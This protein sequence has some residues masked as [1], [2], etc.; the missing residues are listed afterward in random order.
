MKKDL[1]NGVINSASNPPPL[2]INLNSGDDA[3]QFAENII[4]TVREPLIVLDQDLKVVTASRSFYDFFKVKSDETI[5]RLIYDLGNL[6]WN[7]PKLKELLETILPEKTTFD[8][9]EVEHDFPAIGKRVMLL[10]ARQ[11]E[12]A[13]GKEKIILL[14][15]EDITERRHKEKTLSEKNRMT[16]EYLDILLDHA[17]APII[18]WD[19]SFVIKRFNHEFEK[20]SGYT[21]AEVIDKK[22]DILFSEDKIDLTLELIKSNINTDKSEN[23]DIDILT[24]DKDIK[25]V[26]WNSSN[27]FDKEGNKIVA[28]IAQDITRH[29]RTEEALR[30]SEA[31]FRTMVAQSPDGIF[32]TDLSGAFLSVNKAMCDLLKY[33]EEELLSLNIWDIVPKEY[34]PVHKARLA[35]IIKGKSINKAVEY[36]VKGKDGIVHFV[37]VLSTPFYKKEKIIGAQ[38]IARDITERKRAEE[39]LRESEE[40]FRHSFDYSASASC[41]IST[42]GKFQKINKAFCEMTGYEKDELKNLTFTAITHPDDISIGLY[43]IKQMLDGKNVTVSFEKR[44]IRKDKRIIWCHIS[45]SLVRNAN[46][47]PQFFISQII[48]ITE[49]KQKEESLRLFRT[50]LDKSNDAIELIDLAT[51][52]FIDVNEKACTDL[53]YSRSELLSMS[54]FDIDPNQTPQNYQSTVSEFDQSKPIIIESVHR[55]KDGSTFPVEVNITLVKL[56]KMYTIVIVRNL[57]ERKIAEKELAASEE[58]YRLLFQNAAEGILLVDVETKEYKLVNK[59]VCQMFGYTEQEMIGLSIMDMHPPESLDFVISEFESQAQGDRPFSA[60]IPCLRKDGTLFYANI[61]NAVVYIDDRKHNI[62]F[63]TDVT[64]QKEAIGKIKLFRTLI[65]QS[66]DA[67]ELIDLETGSFLDCNEKA[68]QEL[69]YTR[70]ELLS[71]KLFDIDPILTEDSF[72]ERIKLIRDSGSILIEGT[73]RRKD[74]SEYPVEINI[75]YVKLERDYIVAVVRNITERKRAEEEILNL[76]KFPS[77]NPDS[78]LRIAQDGTLQYINEAGMR[79]LS[80]LK[81]RIKQIVPKILHDVVSE[82]FYTGTMQEIQLNIKEKV[83]SFHVKPIIEKG[84]ANLYARDITEL[85]KLETD[86]SA[87]AE[88]AKLGYWEYDVDAGQFIF[89]DQYYRLIH[90]SSTENQG[91]NIMSAEEFAKRLVYPDDASSIANALNAA[92]S[93]PDPNYLGK[94]EARV[95]RDD[96]E[97][98]NVN[99]QFKVLKDS[100]GHTYKVYGVNQDIT[101]QKHAEANLRQKEYMLSQSQRFAHIGSWGWDLKGPIEWSDETYC[102]YGVTPE[103]FIPTVESLDSLIHP[104]DRV[105]MQKWIQANIEGKSPQSLEFRTIMSDGSVHFIKGTGNLIYDDDGKPLYMAGTVQDITE[106]KKAEQELIEAKEKAEEMN[107][108]K[109][110]F[111]ANMSHELRTPLIG[112]LGYAEFLRSELKDKELLEMVNAIRTSGNR[113]NKTLNNILSISK[114][115]SEKQQVNLKEHD[116]LNLLREQIILYKAAAEEKNISLNFETGEEIIN[117]YIDENM[118][119]SIISNLL[120]NAIKYTDIGGV[121]LIAKREKDFAVIEVIDTGIGVSEDLQKIIFDPFRQASEGYGRKFEGTGLGLTLIKKYTDLLSGTLSLKSKPGVG[122]TFI[123]KLP[124]HK[125]ISEGILNTNLE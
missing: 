36:E 117:A 58:R 44:Y 116:L 61:Y 125:N 91:G 93:S 94:G 84:Y 100:S 57:T 30:D 21:S 48:D 80:E 89:N 98:A 31:K 77:E 4:N 41:I 5:G 45:S 15:I 13:F 54:V 14:A 97:V 11:I 111:L 87:A 59:A 83:L 19:S 23:L 107:R 29:R 26:L 68:Y 20:L 9:Y 90:G 121:T 78:V 82:S 101:E 3:G 119:V 25:T 71:L 120:N 122:S 69:G 51:G 38:S 106:L 27:I 63:F 39:K 47:Q 2:K 60:D 33:S 50:L 1:K 112:I 118:F 81:L 108:L 43:Q 73:H 42:E 17:H 32:I 114:I 40:R 92:I 35:D 85:K 72:P 99:V 70:E 52:R 7:I 102:V 22:I 75:K 109:T 62:G 8:N 96:G 95:F 124:V 65:D 34:L 24:K 16:S 88:I 115:E 55:R 79:R 18:I 74:G 110:N 37:E 6:Q 53:G 86:L 105:L 103:M 67:V 66:N 56:E 10:N 49:S 104:E 28:T 64:G 12:R 76:A 46:H 113:L 123:L